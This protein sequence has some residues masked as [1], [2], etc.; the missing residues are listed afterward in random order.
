MPQHAMRKIAMVY[1]VCEEKTREVYAYEG[2]EIK[3][4][5]VVLCGVRRMYRISST[6]SGSQI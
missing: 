5:D 6:S 1:D 3:T 2:S 4:V